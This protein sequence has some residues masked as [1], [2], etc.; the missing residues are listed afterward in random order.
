M[1]KL[2]EEFIRVINDLKLNE[3][4]LNCNFGLEKENLRVNKNG[5]LAST[6]HP[7]IFGDRMENP[8]IK[9]DFSES[10]VEMATGIST[11][12]DAAYDSLGSLQDYVSLNLKN[13]LL[14]P[15]SN[16]PILPQEE[17]IPIANMVDKEEVE[18]REVLSKKYGRKR[19]LISGIHYNFS[20]REEFFKILQSKLSPE[21]SYIEFRNEIYL[22]ISRSFI[23]Y[24]YLLIY[25]TGAS[26]VFHK[27]FISEY[28]EKSKTFDEESCYLDNMLSFR[29]SNYGYKNKKNY[30]VSF[31]SVESYLLAIKNLVKLGALQDIYEFYGPLRLKADKTDMVNNL[32]NFGIEYIELRIFDINPYYKNGISKDALKLVHLFVLFLLFKTDEPLS[33]KDSELGDINSNLIASSGRSKDL[34]IYESFGVRC[35]F[36]TKATALL[37]EMEKMRELLALPES[38]KSIILKAIDEITT[39]SKICSEQV[40]QSI[41]D[42]SFIDFHLEKAEEHLKESI[43][44]QTK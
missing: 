5:T 6:P 33:S 41:K 11:T 40:F 34:Y 23:K 42:S 3:Y 25:F 21:K 39:P 13:E 22:R 8:F 32:N 2:D 16:P 29:N 31:N 26:P 4:L 35:S 10:Q 15:S 30:Y 9:T 36:E 24:R 17:D 43:N 44:T 19:Q 14:W 18:F 28:V 12:T 37:N 7:E 38:Y 20:F 27:S 1:I